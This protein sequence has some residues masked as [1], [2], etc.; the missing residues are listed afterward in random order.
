[1]KH[2]QY[3]ASQMDRYH[4]GAGAVAAAL[5]AETLVHPAM[6]AHPNPRRVAIVGGAG[7]V[8]NEVL[9]HHTAQ[10][11]D[12]FEDHNATILAPPTTDDDTRIH[13]VLFNRKELSEAL[14]HHTT[15]AG[16]YDVIVWNTKYVLLLDKPFG[17]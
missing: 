16:A 13:R 12:V 14:H 8:M 17:S 2:V 7:G 3:V 6:L 5:A 11:V 10:Q 4:R 15:T 9:K 1:M